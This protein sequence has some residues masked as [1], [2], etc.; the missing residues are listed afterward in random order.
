MYDEVKREQDVIK[1]HRIKYSRIWLI[2]SS[3]DSN[4][5]YVLDSIGNFVL[6]QHMVKLDV[7]QLGVAAFLRVGKYQ[8]N[9]SAN[10]KIKTI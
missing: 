4:W 2:H 9:G 5:N 8:K 1:S 6:S 10:F 7:L 3:D